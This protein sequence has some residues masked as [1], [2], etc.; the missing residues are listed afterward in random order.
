MKY[1]PVLIGLFLPVAVFAGEVGPCL[2]DAAPFEVHCKAD[3]VKI[4]QLFAVQVFDGCAGPQDTATVRL[5]FKTEV[6]AAERF[7]LGYYLAL[8]GGDALTGTCQRDYLPPPLYYAPTEAAL[9]SGYGPYP[10]IDGDLCGDGRRG[11]PMH[12]VVTDAAH[13]MGYVP[14]VLPC[15]DNNHNGRLDVSYCATWKNA[16]HEDSCT[17]MDQA[18]VPQT[19]SGCKCGVLDIIPWIPVPTP[20]P[21]RGG[22]VSRISYRKG[23]DRLWLQTTIPDVPGLDLSASFQYVL[24]SSLG[25]V[26]QGEL[27]AGSIVGGKYRSGSQ[28]GISQL[29]VWPANTTDHLRVSLTAYDDVTVPSEDMT[30]SIVFGDAVFTSS[31][32]WRETSTGW[33]VR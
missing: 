10:N 16:D 20:S 9:L 17:G 15:V 31:S 2:Q 27:P 6:Q 21:C 7:D 18:G 5:V 3:D 12:R 29:R 23:L 22:C 1:F 25:I 14:V 13:P 30:L 28:D 11:W 4:S 33:V 24:R 8:D 32:R 26:A 19:A